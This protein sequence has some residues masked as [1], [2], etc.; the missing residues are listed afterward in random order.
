MPLIT[1]DLLVLAAIT[2]GYFAV[3]SYFTTQ[4][5]VK[6]LRDENKTL[7]DTLAASR[8][9]H[10]GEQ[11]VGQQG[12]TYSQQGTAKQE[13]TQ[14]EIRQQIIREPCAGQSVPD[15]SGQRLWRYA[16]Q[17]R[18]AA[19]S[20]AAREPDRLPAGSASGK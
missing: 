17:T 20:D 7:S 4:A 6:T 15:A 9:Q 10:N 3:D 11:V 5:T 12:L 19:L 2:V 13:K 16:E 14:I 1:K 18:A 8:K